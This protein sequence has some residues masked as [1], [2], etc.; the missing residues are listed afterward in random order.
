MTGT[1]TAPHVDWAQLAP[2]IMVLGAAVIGVLVEA[3]VPARVRR[4]V[5]LTLSLV[6]LLGAVT[7]TVPTASNAAR[8]ALILLFILDT[9][10]LV[11]PMAHA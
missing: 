11:C 9:P 3:F 1:F 7:A 10:N 8:P 6:A 2:V 4:P 5:Q